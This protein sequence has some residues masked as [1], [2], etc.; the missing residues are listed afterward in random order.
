LT[1]STYVL[2]GLRQGD[3]RSGVHLS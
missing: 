2:N 3:E 1:A